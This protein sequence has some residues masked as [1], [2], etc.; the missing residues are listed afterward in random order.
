ML[1]ALLIGLMALVMGLEPGVIGIAQEVA[2]GRGGRA[3]AALCDCQGLAVLVCVCQV[4]GGIDS[5]LC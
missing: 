5:R 3:S 2:Q 1:Q 4:S